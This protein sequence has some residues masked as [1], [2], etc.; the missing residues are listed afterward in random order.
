MVKSEHVEFVDKFLKQCYSSPFMS[1]DLYSDKAR[2]ETE[3]V[4]EGELD[5]ARAEFRKLPQWKEVAEVLSAI[6]NPFRGY[7]LSEQLDLEP[8]EVK[9]II[10]FLTRY[11]MIKT[12]PAGYR[13]QPKLNSF[14]RGLT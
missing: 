10:R 3:F 2:A 11:K 8:M 12:L 7:E 14:L 5:A 13:K 6:G 4:G 9:P 1:Y